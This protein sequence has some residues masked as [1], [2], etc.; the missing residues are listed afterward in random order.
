MWPA[1]LKWGERGEGLSVGAYSERD[2]FEKGWSVGAYSERGLC[3]KGRR[4][5]SYS[6]RGL[7]EKG[8]SEK[9]WDE[10]ESGKGMF[11]RKVDIVESWWWY[12]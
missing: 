8:S 11:G 3:E 4:K 6:E 9:C 12:A 5:G 1:C 7:C 10:I 2:L